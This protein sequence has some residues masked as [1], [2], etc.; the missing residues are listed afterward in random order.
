LVECPSCGA[1]VAAAVKS[2]PVS[3]KK[4][5]EDGAKPQ[6]IVGVFE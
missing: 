2:W 3:F 1:E 5:G 6:F 4:Q